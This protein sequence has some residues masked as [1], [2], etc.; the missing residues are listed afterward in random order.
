MP[1]TTI[2]DATDALERLAN[3]ICD[4]PSNEATEWYF[5]H[6]DSIVKLQDAMFDAQKELHWILK[7]WSE[8]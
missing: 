2:E 6:L 8:Q 1:N 3:D 7:H 5:D 4:L